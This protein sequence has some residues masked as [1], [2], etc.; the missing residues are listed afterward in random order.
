MAMR[1]GLKMLRI[2]ARCVEE[3]AQIP[4]ERA[5]QKFLIEFASAFKETDPLETMYRFTSWFEENFPS[6]KQKHF[7]PLLYK[8]CTTYCPMDV[9]KNDERLLKL[10]LK[11]AENFPESGLAIMEF[12][13]AKGSCRQL[14]KFYVHWS[15]MFQSI[16]WWNKAREKLQL[17]QKMCAMPLDL[18][19]GAVDELEA[20]VMRVMRCGTDEISLAV[21]EENSRETLGKL[22][23]LGRRHFAPIIRAAQGPAGTLPSG[24]SKKTSSRVAKAKIGDPFEILADESADCISDEY[25]PTVLFQTPIGTRPGKR[26]FIAE[27]LR[28]DQD[29]QTLFGAFDIQEKVDL[30]ITNEENELNAHGVSA[31]RLPTIPAHTPAQPNFEIFREAGDDDDGQPK[32]A[33]RS[34][35]KLRKEYVQSMSVEE[36]FAHKIVS[37][38]SKERE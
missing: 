23:G 34:K 18:L 11:L 36:G 13:F 24:S 2:F 29:Y 12:A 17:G 16:G 10:W 31:S 7:C 6:G 22:R 19:H 27:S 35:L 3:D 5:E 8:I 33:A 21:S 37:D 15:T 1:I 14:A 32:K 25:P 26:S 20:S 38:K 4:I 9:Y 30:Q 28:N